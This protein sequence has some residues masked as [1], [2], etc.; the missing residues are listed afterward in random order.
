M[1]TIKPIGSFLS[2]DENGFIINTTS[3]ESIQPEWKPAV[4]SLVVAYKKQFG[5]N[6]H[7]LYIRGSVAKGKAIKDISDIDTI[8]VLHSKSSRVPRTKAVQEEILTAYPFVRRIEFGIH[9]LDKLG[10]FTKL[11][12]QTQS[13]CVFGEDLTKTI[14]AFKVGKDTQQHIHSLEKEISS[15][16]NYLEDKHTPDE[17]KE[18]CSWTMKRIVRSGCELVMER[19]GKYTRDLYPCYTVFSEY[20]P[21]QKE[22]MHQILEFAITPSDNAQAVIEILENFGSWIVREIKKES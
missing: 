6:L 4:D 11:M 12:I 14:P 5:D 8:A 21:E 7:S 17:I 18:S 13:V 15:E 1:T 22:R 2:T 16:L 10:M 19:S 9:S 3:I 20:Y